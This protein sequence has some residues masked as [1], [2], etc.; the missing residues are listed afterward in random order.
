[1]TD[2]TYD[3]R[4]PKERVAVLIGKS[5]EVKKQIEQITKTKIEVDSKEG[6]VSVTGDDPITLLNVREIIKA[7]GRGFNPDIALVLLKAD[8]SFELVNVADYVRN[9]NDLI[10]IRGRVIGAEGKSRR[11]I[12]ELTETDICVFGKTIGIIGQLENV[13]LCRR[14]IMTLLSGS[15]HSSVYHWLEKKRA[16]MKRGSM[17]GDVKLDDD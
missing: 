11:T 17:I 13:A 1:M 15:P 14:A 12:E 3:L 2:Y 9:K 5:G 8:Y 16:A 10:R 6:D 4:I 7:V